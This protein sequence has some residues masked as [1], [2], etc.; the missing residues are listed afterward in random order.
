VTAA[1]VVRGVEDPTLNSI[2][3]Q[4]LAATSVTQASILWHQADREVM[5]QAAIFPIAD[6]NEPLVHGSQVHNCFDIAAIQEC[7]PTNVWLS[8]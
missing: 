8:G 2:I 1:D 6:P 7:D 5:S 4:A 3:N